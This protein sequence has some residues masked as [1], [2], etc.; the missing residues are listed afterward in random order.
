MNKLFGYV[1]VSVQF[2]CIMYLFLTSPFDDISLFINL[3]F[4]VGAALGLWAVATMKRSKF[5]IIPD[6]HEQ[7]VLVTSGPYK[8]IRHPM[9]AALI[10]SCLGFLM[11]NV[12]SLRLFIYI[13]L[14][15]DL[16][17]K[18]LYEETLLSRHFQQYYKY[19]QATSR[20]IPFI[21]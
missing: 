11:I 7:A 17:I 16:I 15:I 19:A 20:L 13:V 10:I 14:F 12:N 21:F 5:R 1:L 4:L 9:Y 2:T 18:L 6:V 8:F 3:P